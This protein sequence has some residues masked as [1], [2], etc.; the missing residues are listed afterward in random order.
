MEKRGKRAGGSPD[1]E[2]LHLPTV[3]GKSIIMYRNYTFSY[4]NRKHLL[5]CSKA[6]RGKC[7]AKIKLD[8]S[9]NIL[10]VD[11]NHN[12]PPP[13][14]CKT[15]QGLYVKGKQIILYKGYSYSCVKGNQ[16]LRCSRRLA[17]RCNARI[18][19]DTDG[20]IVYAS[21]F[22]QHNHPPPRY[23]RTS[24]DYQ[25]ETLQIGKG[26]SVV[27]VN[28]YTYA[29]TGPGKRYLKCSQK[30]KT[31]CKARMQMGDDGAIRFID[32]AHNHP[33]PKYHKTS[34]GIYLALR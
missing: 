34:S 30:L 25:Y 17:R 21:T 18:T 4:R 23:M 16:Y 3:G 13:K 29:Y 2:I 15:A 14:Y 28:E 22:T 24:E 1:D 10:I 32:A 6:M 19:L 9:G 33:P 12:H 26:R 20:N 11:T 31:G 7:E 27:M 5:R 8:D